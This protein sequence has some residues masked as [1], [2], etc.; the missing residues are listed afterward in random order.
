MPNPSDKNPTADKETKSAQESNSKNAGTSGGASK[1]STF[2]SE[3]K[4]EVQNGGKSVEESNPTT[5]SAFPSP[6]KNTNNPAVPSTAR[7]LGAVTLQDDEEREK[8]PRA[9][10][11]V[12]GNT[13]AEAQV[14]TSSGSADTLQRIERVLRDGGMDSMSTIKSLQAIGSILDDA[15]TKRQGGTVDNRTPEQKLDEQNKSVGVNK[16]K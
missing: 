5:P 1:A 11:S 13:S 10:K 7:P 16:D 12:I 3:G 15:E 4:T 2:T 9:D 14:P 6:D 8:N